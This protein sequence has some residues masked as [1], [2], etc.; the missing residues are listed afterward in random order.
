[1]GALAEAWTWIGA[2]PAPFWTALR[3]HLMLS[4]AAL[5]IGIAVAVPLGL[6][7]SR[8]PGVA[9]A[10]INI[11]GVGRTIPS[12]A[13]L[14]LML[15]LV[16]T[17]FLPSLI[18]LSIYAVPPILVN[19]YVGIR[20]IDADVIDA[21]RGM[22]LSNGGILRRIE[23]PLALPVIFAGIRTAAVQV[24]AGATLAT[25]IGGG[26]LGDFIAQGVQINSTAR[27]LVGAV[28]VTLMAIATELI[29]GAA[30]RRLRRDARAG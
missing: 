14:A 21:A 24:V 29:F 22:G 27:L 30:E 2:H 16:G 23:I 19:A 1:M 6:Y 15:P 4:G 26:G 25:F 18:A 28:P 7:L 5:G 8:R 13:L 9:D 12:L 3:V 11:V 10:V 20:Q 17:G